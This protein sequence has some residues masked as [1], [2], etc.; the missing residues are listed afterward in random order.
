MYAKKMILETDKKGIIRKIPVLPANKK[1]EAIFL[2]IEDLS[3]KQVVERKPHFNIAGK[4]QLKG[5]IFNTVSK[6]DWDMPEHHSDPQDRIIIATSLAHD[7]RLM[8][9]D[10]KFSLY[11]ELK[12]ILI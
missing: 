10:K 1:Y 12:N 7:A 2:V 11:K 8:S 5:D 6:N 3:E 4:I 9:S